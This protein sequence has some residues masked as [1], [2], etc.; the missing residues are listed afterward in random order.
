MGVHFPIGCQGCV[1]RDADASGPMMRM[2]TDP[3]DEGVRLFKRYS[4]DPY[5]FALSL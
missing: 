1:P 3:H 5:V 4:Y 2:T